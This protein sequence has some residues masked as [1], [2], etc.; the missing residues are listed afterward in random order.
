MKGWYS[1]MRQILSTFAQ[2]PE[3][4]TMSETFY[5][6][7]RSTAGCEVWA[8]RRGVKSHLPHRLDLWNHS[9]TGLEW[10][11]GGSG[12]AQ[13]ALALLADVLKDDLQAVEYHQPFKWEVVA[14]LE[15]EG[16]KLSFDKI[17]KWVEAHDQELQDQQHGRDF[18]PGGID[19]AADVVEGTG[20]EN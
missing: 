8:V 4:C 14:R 13:L 10:G 5:E 15:H 6:G 17:L 7:R 18:P 11:Y 9:P 20:N 19:L 2:T 16:W 3:G 12:P 1:Y